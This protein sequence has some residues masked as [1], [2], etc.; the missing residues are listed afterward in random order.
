MF[1]RHG[2]CL[3]LALRRRLKT[4]PEMAK[5]GI[6]ND[7]LYVIC[8]QGSETCEHL[9]F[10]CMYTREVWK[11][12]LRGIGIL[13]RPLRW[14]DELRWIV[15]KCKGKSRDAKAVSTACASVIDELWRERNRRLFRNEAKDHQVVVDL[16]KKF[17][18]QF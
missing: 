13:R 3:W 14:T 9:F 4:K 6:Q 11:S 15:R 18:L 7:G 10:E 16:V 2:F 12:V 17:L 8:S 1:P 5:R